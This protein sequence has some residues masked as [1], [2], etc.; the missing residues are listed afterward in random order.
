MFVYIDSHLSLKVQY[1]STFIY[2]YVGYL[3]DNLHGHLDIHRL[4][5]ER[6]LSVANIV[7]SILALTNSIKFWRVLS[8]I[9]VWQPHSDCE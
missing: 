7:H 6:S 8:S 2:V 9:N 4:P 1:S 5:Y 3:Q